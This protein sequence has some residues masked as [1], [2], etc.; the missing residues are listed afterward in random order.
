MQ[1]CTTIRAAL[2][3]DPTSTD[4]ALASHVATCT[5]CAAYARR[6]AALD[7]AL[8]TELRWEA[9]PD[10]TS[11]LLSLAF[12]P[13]MLGGAAHPKRWHVV[14]A[15]MVTA[16]SIALSV[17]IGWQVVMLLAANFDLQAQF[18]QLMAL[19]GHWLSQLTQSMPESRYV[20]DFLLRAR[21][22]L[23]WLLLVALVWAVLDTWNPQF[24][25]RLRRRQGA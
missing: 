4:A 17:L 21:T 25:V 2:A 9:P 6:H 3:L 24:N 13:A 22:Q 16:V 15:Y 5:S 19:P 14:L 7:R 8:G 23:V 12:T 18:T 1:P 20:V 11:A 10:L